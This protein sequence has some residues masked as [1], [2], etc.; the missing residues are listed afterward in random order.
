MSLDDPGVVKAQ[1]A[2]EAGLETRRSVYATQE[3]E[4]PLE[5]AFAAIA[6]C[7]PHRVL[8]VGCGPGEL[9]VRMTAELGAEVVAVD[10]SERMVELARAKGV[11]ARLGDVQSMPFPDGSF[12]TVVAAHM[13]YHVTD[14]DGGLTEIGRVLT[15]RGRLVAT[16]NSES[17]LEEAR[18]HAGVSMVGRVS[19]NRENGRKILERHFATVEQIDVDGWVTFADADAIRRYIRSMIMFA[20]ESNADRV[21]DDVGPVRAGT[22]VT[23]FVARRG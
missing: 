1:Y 6:A 22:R 8:E 10:V 15:E 16:T 18:V 14:L 21:P 17:H 13:L 5:V 7:H 23:V 20:D 11:G 12:D 2:T 3:C 9:S 4:D 19:F